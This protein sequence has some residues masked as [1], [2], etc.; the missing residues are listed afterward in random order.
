MAG[1]PRFLHSEATSEVEAL[2][3]TAHWCYARGWVPATSGNFSIREPGR[4]DTGRILVTPSGLD[5]G[6]LKPEDLIEVDTGGRVVAGAGKPSAETGLHLVLY[7][8]RPEAGAIVHVHTVWNT[9]ISGHYAPRGYAP[10]EG[11]EILKGL[12]G[13]T[14]HAHLERVP[15]LENAQTYDQLCEEMTEAL[16]KCP[17]AH[18]VLLSRHGLYTWGQSMA[19]ARRHLEV[20]EFLFEVE[21]RR[22]TGSASME[23]DVIGATEARGA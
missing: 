16:E 9:L 3:A 21:M 14:T 11:Y 20:L 17:R 2:C 23:R 22:L 4:P 10:L 12:S 1:D 15:I 8:E 5:K 18:G 7:R 6:A 13:V 19:E